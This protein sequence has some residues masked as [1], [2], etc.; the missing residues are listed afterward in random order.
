MK[1]ILFLNTFTFFLSCRGTSLMPVILP[2]IIAS[3]NGKTQ[4]RFFFHLC[5]HTSKQL[6]KQ[7]QQQHGEKRKGEKSGRRRRIKYKIHTKCNYRLVIVKIVWKKN[8][9][10][11]PIAY[12]LASLRTRHYETVVSIFLCATLYNFYM[13][14]IFD[15]RIAYMYKVY[16]FLAFTFVYVM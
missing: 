13:Y 5:L 12:V 16:T 10:R 15:V 9:I 1:L 11:T 2:E 14:K 4:H 8:L 7:Q 3:S 6:E